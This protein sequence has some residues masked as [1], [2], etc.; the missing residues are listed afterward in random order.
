MYGARGASVERRLP[1]S[2]TPTVEAQLGGPGAHRADDE[3]DVCVELR[4]YPQL[5]RAEE[6]VVAVDATS[7]G[8]VLHFLSYRS[9]VDFVEA[10]GGSDQGGGGDQSRQLVDGEQGLGH[11][12]LAGDTG[13]SCVS[14]DCLEDVLGPAALARK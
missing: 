8:L 10:L 4:L 13:G 5:P 12:R 2:D 14:Q 1:H 9:R 3:L 7:E 6:H 11:G